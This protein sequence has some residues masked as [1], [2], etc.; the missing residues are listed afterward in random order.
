[1]RRDGAGGDGALVAPRMDSLWHAA[2][3][4]LSAADQ[5]RLAQ[6]DAFRRALRRRLM[7]SGRQI[8]EEAI[9]RCGLTGD[10]LT[11]A[12]ARAR[13][14]EH[15]RRVCAVEFELYRLVVTE[16]VKEAKFADRPT[17]VSY[18]KLVNSIL[19]LML[20]LVD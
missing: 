19:E 3:G 6:F 7:P 13:F 15:L 1:V 4:A 9:A 17:V 16:D 12:E 5:Q 18:A 10:K 2:G 14:S 8:A 11:R 20:R